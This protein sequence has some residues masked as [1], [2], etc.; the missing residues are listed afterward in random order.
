MTY[1]MYF[2]RFW[3][4]QFDEFHTWYEGYVPTSLY[5]YWA[6]ATWRQFRLDEFDANSEWSLDGVSLTRAA[7]LL[8]ERW[9][10]DTE[11]A[12]HVAKF[13]NLMLTLKD[14]SAAPDMTGLLKRYGPTRRDRIAALFYFGN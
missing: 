6:W 4:L 10:V 9:A 5:A 2:D 7:G 8:R 14:S 13:V 1:K 11:Q 12:F 3:S